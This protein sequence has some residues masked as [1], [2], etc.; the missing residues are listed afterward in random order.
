MDTLHGELVLGMMNRIVCRGNLLKSSF[1]SSSRIGYSS[2]YDTGSIRS[3]TSTGILSN[4]KSKLTGGGNVDGNKGNN[5]NEDL[6]KG[7]KSKLDH[8]KDL[9]SKYKSLLVKNI[10]NVKEA[11]REANRKFAE[12]EAQAGVDSKLSY[13]KD[14]STG[15]VIGGLP[16]EREIRRR[17]WSRRLEFYLDSLQETIFSASKAF[18]DVTGYSSIQKLRKSIDLLQIQLEVMKRELKTLRVDYEESIE[19]RINSQRQVN[20]L[21]QRKSS[22]SATDLENF[23]QLYKDDATNSKRE[24][25][26][27]TELK[28]KEEA[29][30][31]ITDELYSAILTRYHEEQIW[32]DKIRRTSIWST[33][34]LMAVNLFL[35]VILQLFLEPWKRR[36]LVRAFE[37]NVRTSL[38]AQA[39]DHQ[40]HYEQ[41]NAQLQEQSRLIQQELEMEKFKDDKRKQD[42]PQTPSTIWGW[43]LQ[44]INKL[45]NLSPMDMNCQTN[46]NTL[47]IY[48]LVTSVGVISSILTTLIS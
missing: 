6:L 26:L 7:F 29:Q 15:G 17:K 2:I 5:G 43:F 40:L 14:V 18:N 20:E 31:K 10:D 33:F 42:E 32:S 44:L 4:S 41:L 34:M 12:Q 23:T 48:L 35:F 1:Y 25:D 9:F 19:K 38:E 46:F 37:R 21:L 24:Q 11:I 22:W 47:Q 30:E 45:Q 13:N 28:N 27:K 8:S 36:R 16:S 3:F 39:A